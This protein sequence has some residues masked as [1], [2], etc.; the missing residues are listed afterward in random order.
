MKRKLFLVG[1]VL[2]FA[3]LLVGCSGGGIVSPATDE[4]K[5]KSVINEYFLAI[6]DQNWS[7]AK[8]YCV[9]G[10]NVYYETCLLEDEVNAVCQY[11]NNVAI[12][13]AINISKVSVNG[14]YASAYC[15]GTIATI[16]DGIHNSDTASVYLYLQ[17]VGNSWKIDSSD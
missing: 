14:S 8:S 10:S 12:I 7:K 5:V 1:L 9:S 17:K 4:A 6:N 11:S 3:M 15:S 13:C 2:L 16:V